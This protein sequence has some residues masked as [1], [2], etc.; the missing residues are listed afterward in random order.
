MLCAPNGNTFF[1]K[2]MCGKKCRFYEKGINYCIL[3]TKNMFLLHDNQS[4]NI[5]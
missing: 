3:R 2:D 4:V 1:R 5:E